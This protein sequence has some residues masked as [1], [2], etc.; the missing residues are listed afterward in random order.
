MRNLKRLN[1]RKL[2]KTDFL[3]VF[4]MAFRNFFEI[5][6]NIFTYDK[7]KTI[8]RALIYKIHQKHFFHPKKLEAFRISIFHSKLTVEMHD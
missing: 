8:K 1:M 3:L 7:F 2:T 5:V 4:E 6:W